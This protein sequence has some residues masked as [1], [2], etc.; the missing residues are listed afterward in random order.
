MK[1]VKATFNGKEF[2]LPANNSNW[3]SNS[4]MP[5]PEGITAEFLKNLPRVGRDSKGMPIVQDDNGKRIVLGGAD[6]RRPDEKHIVSGGSGNTV[7]VSKQVLWEDLEESK[8]KA[9][10]EI[11]KAC[12]KDQN[13][14]KLFD[15]IRPK[16]KE[17]QAA[18]DAEAKKAAKIAALKAQLAALEAEA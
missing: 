6:F 16:T 8:Q 7:Y 12:K 17:E 1:I 5:L 14:L 3:I 13:L 4:E 2:L 15:E 9:W 11:K 10:E 18:I